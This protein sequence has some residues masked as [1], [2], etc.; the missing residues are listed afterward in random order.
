MDFPLEPAQAAIF[1]ERI[2]KAV[3]VDGGGFQ[4]DY[5]IVELHGMKCRHDF[6]RQQFSTSQVV[7]H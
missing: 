7:L 2:N 4:T 5:H 6:L 1:T 3:P